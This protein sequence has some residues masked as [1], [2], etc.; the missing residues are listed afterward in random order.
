MELGGAA[1]SLLIQKRQWMLP[2]PWRMHRLSERQAAPSDNCRSG[3]WR[4]CATWDVK[5][6]ELPCVTNARIEEKKSTLH[7]TCAPAQLHPSR[8]VQNNVHSE[9]EVE[10]VF[11]FRV[12][13]FLEP[14][15]DMMKNPD[16]R[17]HV[18]MWHFSAC[19]SKSV[20]T[21]LFQTHK[22]GWI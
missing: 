7:S 4:L 17:Y 18:H 11:F 10:R 22:N 20:K 9:K 6:T 15:S 1:V 3:G 21:I 8:L 12:L 13:L 2:A 14:S 5:T 16:P 19:K